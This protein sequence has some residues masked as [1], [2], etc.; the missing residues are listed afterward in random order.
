[1]LPLSKTEAEIINYLYK[2]RDKTLYA[3]EIAKGLNL[4]KRTVYRSLESLKRKGIVVEEVRGR[5]KFYK[6]SEKW[7]GV[8][9]AAKVYAET[10]EKMAVREKKELA[11]SVSSEDIKTTLNVLETLELMRV[12]SSP[13]IEEVKK[14]LKKLERTGV[15]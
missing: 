3:I 11:S 5:M 10:D 4:Q 9:E 12:L 14:A 2:H 7:F 15:Q 6:L 1:M 13:T 8:A